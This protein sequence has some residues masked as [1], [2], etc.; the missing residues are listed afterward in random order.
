MWR[1]RFWNADN[2]KGQAGEGLRRGWERLRKEVYR[3]G[4]AHGENSSRE[5]WRHEGGGRKG[6]G[7]EGPRA[8]LGS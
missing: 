5:G 8:E 6:P 3:S 1:G 7:I 4:K 2:D